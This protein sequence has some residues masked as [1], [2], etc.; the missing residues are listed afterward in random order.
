MV[1]MAKI[2]QAFELVSGNVTRLEQALETDF[3]EALVEQNA[4]YLENLGRNLAL[5]DDE[6]PQQNLPEAV[7]KAVKTANQQLAQLNLSPQE[8]QK[9]FQF[10]L[11]KGAQEAPLQPNHAFTPDAIAVLFA[12]IIE[13]LMGLDAENAEKTSLR[14]LD[15][16]SGTG[17]LGEYLLTNLPAKLEYV[18]FEID[19]LL[20][21]I[22]ASMAEIIGTSPVF[23]QV[24]AVETQLLAPVDVVVG[25]L[26]VGFYPDN[27]LASHFAVANP[28][29]HSFAHQLMIEQSFRYLKDDG[30]AVFLAPEELLT[31]AQAPLLKNWLEKNGSLLAILTLPESLFNTDSRAIY[32]FK[33]GKNELPTFV[34]PLQSLTDRALLSEF[35]DEFL[36][37]VK[38]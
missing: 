21:D 22:A 34:Y 32:V 18:G 28:D 14:L 12:F 17:N 25:D 11:L 15:F 6:L 33:K 5:D 9:L 37:N 26:P 29:G 36:K 20:L 24:N 35:M 16:G 10:V 1:D 38:M 8:W 2:E 30:L 3:Y 4:S 13:N 31:T 27:A 7:Q 19:D 23:M